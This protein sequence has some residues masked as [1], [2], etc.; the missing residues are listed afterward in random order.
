MSWGKDGGGGRGIQSRAICASQRHTSFSIKE[1]IKMSFFVAD[2]IDI[3]LIQICSSSYNRSSR[4][5]IS[6]SPHPIFFL[7]FAMILSA[8][9][10]LFTSIIC[11]VFSCW[12]IHERYARWFGLIARKIFVLIY[13]LNIWFTNIVFVK[14]LITSFMFH[15][16]PVLCSGGHT[17][18]RFPNGGDRRST[19]LP[20]KQLPPWKFLLFLHAC[21]FDHSNNSDVQFFST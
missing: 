14:E 10:F 19:L 6:H 8:I 1:R 11:I 16:A 20:P 18:C 4:C 5:F 15:S 12:N 7:C 9:L 13:L 3:G 2:D 17:A 21:S